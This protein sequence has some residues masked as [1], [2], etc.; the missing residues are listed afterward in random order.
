M[1]NYQLIKDLEKRVKELEDTNKILI[2]GNELLY[3]NCKYLTVKEFVQLLC[4]YLGIYVKS[5][6]VTLVT[7]KKESDNG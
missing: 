1:S 6:S 7:K 4:D 2:N 3:Q 5:E